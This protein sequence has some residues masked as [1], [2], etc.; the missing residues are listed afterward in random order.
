MAHALCS[1]SVDF[2]KEFRDFILSIDPARFRKD[3]EV[4]TRQRVRQLR[5]KLDQILAAYEKSTLDSRLG[6][7]YEGLKTLAGQLDD[8]EQ[9]EGPVRREWQRYQ[10]RLQTSYAL[11][12]KR[13]DRLSA[14][15]PTLRITNYARNLFHASMAAFTIALI[16][17][18]LT[19]DQQKIAAI[20][21]AAF[22]WLSELGRTLSRRFTLAYLKV[23]G[24]I[25]HTHEQH[26]V[27]SAT[28]YGTALACL[29]VTV[30]PMAATVGVAVLGVGDPMA[31]LVGRR[32]GRTRLRGERTLEGSLAFLVSG[33]LVALLA[34]ATFYPEIA[35][36]RCFLTA[37][38]AA[39]LGAAAELFSFRLD[40]N[41][42]I[43][44]AAALGATLV[45]SLSA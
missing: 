40:D 38:A 5:Q 6:R 43:P 13:L 4:A 21:F 18:F 44:L 34:L 27:N 2:A 31:A 41:L 30:S 20:G 1:E 45:L 26:R 35:L 24:P 33:W 8:Q 23:F 29:S 7:L 36:W 17:F 25:S 9:P 37:G 42:T 14:P 12:A 11:L 32:F 19:P 28:W 15:V 16:Q 39:T 22:C 10:R 3:L